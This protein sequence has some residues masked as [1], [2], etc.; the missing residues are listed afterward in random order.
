MRSAASPRRP[1]RPGQTRVVFLVPGPVLENLGADQVVLGLADGRLDALGGEAGLVAGD[2]LHHVLDRAEAVG[3]VVDGE[4]RI[5]AHELGVIAQQPGAEA[6]EGAH[7]DLRAGHQGLDA[8]PHLAGRLVG[9]GD[10]QDV[11]G[12]DA[13][14]EQVGDP[15]RDDAGLAARRRPAPA[16]ALDVRDRLALGRRQIGK[17]VH[18]E[19]VVLVRG[20]LLPRERSRQ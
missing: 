17:Q 18:G 10:G 6:V 2:L 16:G 3:L 20:V 14:V 15:P 13:R 8:L 4:S 7:P 5:D 1:R 11:L 19:W 12:R 9:E